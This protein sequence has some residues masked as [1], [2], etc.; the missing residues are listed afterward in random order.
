MAQ[1]CFC[2]KAFP[3]VCILLWNKWRVFQIKKRI[4]SGMT[5]LLKSNRVSVDYKRLDRSFA[6]IIANFHTELK[7][8]VNVSQDMNSLA[9]TQCITFD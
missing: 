2:L 9:F 4:N 7:P 8:Q 3:I 1:A 5:W 6:F